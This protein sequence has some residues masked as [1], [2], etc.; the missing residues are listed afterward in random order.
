M[1]IQVIV[2]GVLPH[3]VLVGHKRLESPLHEGAN[4]PLAR[5]SLPL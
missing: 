5:E 3:W 1:P 2:V 4:Q